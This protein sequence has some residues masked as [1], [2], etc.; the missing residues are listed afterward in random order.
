MM[1]IKGTVQHKMEKL[2]LS[3]LPVVLF[4]PLDSFGVIFWVLKILAIERG[5][6]SVT[7]WHK[8]LQ[9]TD[10]VDQFHRGTL[11]SSVCLFLAL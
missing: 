6:L 11:N 4:I 2:V 10:S 5:P 3:P 8:K 1:T 9:T 7:S